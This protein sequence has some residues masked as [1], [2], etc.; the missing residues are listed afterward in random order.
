MGVEGPPVRGWS[1]AEVVALVALLLAGVVATVVL[2]AI[3]DL[4]LRQHCSDE[5][6]AV[7]IWTATVDRAGTV[8]AWV[9][10]LLG[11]AVLPSRRKVAA[12]AVP[13]VAI[14][15]VGVATTVLGPRV[16]DAG[17]PTPADIHASCFF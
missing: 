10:A 9:V 8:V 11:L 15:L 5:P 16:V 3:D 12:A 1:V 7:A 14:V 6:N 4:N 13:V 17:P 2:A